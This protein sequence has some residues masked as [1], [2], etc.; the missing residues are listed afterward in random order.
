MSQEITYTL[1]QRDYLVLRDA[2][3][4]AFYDLEYHLE[5]G[6]Y[7][8]LLATIL[9]ACIDAKKDASDLSLDDYQLHL[10]EKTRRD[11]ALLHNTH[12]IVPRGE[13]SEI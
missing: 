4:E 11:L 12:T 6:D 9:G 2:P 1:T 8:G 13:M 10:L 3:G 5:Q 7:F